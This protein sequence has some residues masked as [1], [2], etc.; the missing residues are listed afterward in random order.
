MAGANHEE[1][2]VEG[3]DVAAI[4]RYLAETDVRFA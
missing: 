3:V 2:P 4:R 1:L